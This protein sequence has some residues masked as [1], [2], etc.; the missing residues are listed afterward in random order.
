MD[1]AAVSQAAG[2][3][4]VDVSLRTATW[5]VMMHHQVLDA[6]AQW[7]R[8]TPHATLKRADQGAT[9]RYQ[10]NNYTHNC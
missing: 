1:A 5:T 3:H 8:L 4:V 10:T 2:P 6:K 9:R 7:P